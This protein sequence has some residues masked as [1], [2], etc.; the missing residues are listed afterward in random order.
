MN[1]GNKLAIMFATVSICVLAVC[2]FLLNGQD[3]EP[4]E[5][6]FGQSRVV[7]RDGMDTAELLKGVEARDRHDGDVTDQ[8]VIEKI[9]KTSDGRSVIVTYAAGDRSNNFA[10][11]SRL[12]QARDLDTDGDANKSDSRSTYKVEAGAGAVTDVPIA[13]GTEGAEGSGGNPEAEETETTDDRTEAGTEEEP[14]KEQQP[15]E[16][17][18]PEEPAENVQN[19]AVPVIKLNTA[20]ATLKKGSFFNINDYI[21]QLSDD[22]DTTETLQ[23]RIR[24]NGEFDNNTVGDYRVTVMV[25]DSEGNTS[26]AQNLLIHVTE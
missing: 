16:E 22:V 4:P 6:S 12:F 7:Y 5:I 23:H 11:A 8:I 2:A 1:L 20:E 25:T 14:E 3:R 21:A 24:T 26:G 9:T 13:S 19:K 18:K 10:K 17:Q 15:P